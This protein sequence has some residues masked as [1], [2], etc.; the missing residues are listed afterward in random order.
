MNI[1]FLV[2]ALA[3]LGTALASENQTHCVITFTKS[4]P[5]TSCETI[6]DIVHTTTIRVNPGCSYNFETC[7]VEFESAARLAIAA[8][9]SVQFKDT[10]IT[11]EGLIALAGELFANAASI[12]HNKNIISIASTGIFN[13]NDQS[14][15]LNDGS[16]VNTVSL[17]ISPINF[18]HL[19][20]F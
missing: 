10:L 4:T 1:A 3:L 14:Y 2:A 6:D 12:V 20:A 17:S 9:G 18:V 16:V 7:I 13:N 15:F 19:L 11:N 8:G 5:E